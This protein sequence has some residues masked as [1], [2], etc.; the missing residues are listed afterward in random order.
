MHPT[1]RS[2]VALVVLAGALGAQSP[3]TVV[4]EGQALPGGGTVTGIRFVHMIP[5]GY[6]LV[7]VTT[8]QP[9]RPSAVLRREG[10]WPAAGPVWKQVGD[11]VTQPAGARIAGFDSFTNELFGGVCWNARLQDTPGGDTDDE[12]LYFESSLWIQ[13]GPI[14][15]W[16]QTDFP[17]GSRWLSFD[18]LRCSLQSGEVLLRGHAD[19]PTMAGPDETFVA[20]GGLCGSIGILCTLDR[21]GQEGWPAVGTGRLIE[22]VRLEPGAAAVSPNSYRFLWSCDLE[23]PAETDGCVYSFSY[24]A[25]NELLAQEGSQSPVAGRRWGPLDDLGLQV[26]SSGSW[27]MR[28]TLDAGDLTSDALIVKDGA[29]FVREGD[30]VPDIAPFTFDGF[31][32]GRAQLDQSGSVV[33]YGRWDE[34]GHPS[35]ALFRDDRLLVRTGQTTI[36]GRLLVGL[37]SGPDDLALTPQGEL[38]IFKGTLEGGVEGAFVLEL[39]P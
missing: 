16:P 8:D 7:Q 35:A 26:N 4:L 6:W 3:R 33:W 18:D 38:L 9:H 28:A 19:D 24:P 27:T 39:G 14:G 13:E 5:G 25:Q 29:V 36:D 37:S 15:S 21:I 20:V 22:A 23:G 17:A 31:G 30:S 1:T 10:L 32:R 11:P 12:A 34:H 2:L